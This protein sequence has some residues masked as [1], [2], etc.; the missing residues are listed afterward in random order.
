LLEEVEGVEL[1]EV[2]EAEQV[3]I[4]HLFLEEHK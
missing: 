2:V 1:M 3:D 4:V